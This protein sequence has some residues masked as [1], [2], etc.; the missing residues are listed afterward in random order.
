MI[1]P[2]FRLSS[3]NL[4]VLAVALLQL[5]RRDHCW[6]LAT[7]AADMTKSGHSRTTAVLED[8]KAFHAYA[9][10]SVDVSDAHVA[11][12]GG[13][14][15]TLI[16]SV[17][18]L[19]QGKRR[20]YL[21]NIPLATTY[22]ST[23]VL[24][25]VELPD[26]ILT[27][28]PSPTGAKVA[29]F[30]EESVRDAPKRQ[31][32]LEIWSEGGQALLRRILMPE[33]MHGKLI[34]DGTGFGIPSWNAQETA[35]VYVA[36]RLSPKTTSFFDDQYEDLVT[37]SNDIDTQVTRGG[38]H[39]MGLGKTERWGEKYFKHSALLDLFCVHIETGRSGKI[40]NCP[41][42]DDDAK[43]TE[44]SYALGQPVFSPDGLSVVY[45]A[46]DAGGGTD[47]PRRLGLIYCQQRPSKLF[48]SPVVK[49][50]EGLAT[51][52][53]L[54]ED[55]VERDGAAICLTLD[56]RLARSPRFSPPNDK[57]Q[58]KL[59]FLCSDRGFDTHSGCLGLHSM[60]WKDDQPV[61][62]TRRTLVK[63]VWNPN[64]SP[65]SA[66]SVMGLLFPG[67]FLLALPESSFLSSEYLLATT[68]WGSSSRIVRISLQT[69]ELKVISTSVEG[70]YSDTL[71]CAS[72]DGGVTF[73]TSGP[74]R[75]STLWHVAASALVESTTLLEADKQRLPDMLPIAASRFSSVPMS[76]R[77]DF[78][79][80][81]QLLSDLPRVVGVK[82]EGIP[83]HTILLMPDLSKHPSPALIVVPHGGPHSV[84][85]TNYLPS[86]AFLCG[87]GGY[88]VALVNYRGST[89]FGQGLVESL[90]MRIGE[91]DVKDVVE[92]TK[93]IRDSGL[94]DP[95][96]IGICGGSHGGFLAGHC[97][98]QFPELF[99]VAAMRNPVVNL[100]S[101]TTATDIPDWTFV[102]ALGT[103]DWQD[104]RPP[105]PDELQVMWQK[106]PV[107][108][109]HNVTAPTLVALG[110]KDLRV[111]PSQ[112]L[113]WY[114]TLRAR[115]VPTKLLT[116]EEDDHAIAG[117]EAEADH[118]VNVRLSQIPLSPSRLS[119]LTLAMP[120][121]AIQ[122]KRWFD[123]H[124]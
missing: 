22:T 70:H 78:N 38:K 114:H 73:K 29:I 4:C 57:G 40:S 71:L 63:E 109:V 48:A 9:A 2:S 64:D 17:R 84:S 72:L 77:L 7:A 85:S 87:H 101:M 43:T 34:L 93:K 92:A 102:E 30:R 8:A 75:I 91:L 16:R 80:D 6:G 95:N 83:V 119:S 27:R 1:L 28:I 10:A 121:A 106:S 122:I 47:M 88:A 60:D 90:P 86:Y 59:V 55:K 61:P 110:L 52:E 58:T 50:M 20:R 32:V 21:Y 39:T 67:L 76:P 81:I 99:R 120:F 44:G 45:T 12:T 74:N 41:G 79:C 82:V 97:T 69:G 65:A 111:P 123:E 94:V 14:L 62:L 118:W 117:V 35:L 49:L 51:A 36:E 108:Y 19:D 46:W 37:N 68:Q 31:Q 103:Y 5:S 112:G 107:R 25:P 98:G 33:S 124:L 53:T 100:P 26:S 96:R 13:G 15:L 115:R 3:R 56:S 105:T 18:D 113:E 24:P 66:G 23:L 104:Y 116:Y 89:G 54:T 42:A 11:R